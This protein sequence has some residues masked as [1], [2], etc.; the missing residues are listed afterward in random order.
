M[1]SIWE[2][3]TYIQ[4]KLISFLEDFSILKDQLFEIREELA[5][6]RRSFRELQ[7]VCVEMAEQ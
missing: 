7:E 3:I 5:Q 2:V 4:N 6:Q 1:D